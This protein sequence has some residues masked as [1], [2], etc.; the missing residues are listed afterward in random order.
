MGT[1]KIIIIFNNS[2]RN[3]E[4]INRLLELKP[5]KMAEENLNYGKSDKY[6]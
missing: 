2:Y 3:V 1:G 5:T 4:V 6:S